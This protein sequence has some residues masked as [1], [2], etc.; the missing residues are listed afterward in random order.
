MKIKTSA[1]EVILYFRYNKREG[2]TNPDTRC[3][4]D[5]AVKA[6]VT[7]A[8]HFKDQFVRSVGRRISLTRALKASGASREIRA[9]IWNAYREATRK[10]P[11]T[12]AIT[13]DASK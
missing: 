13:I 3:V 2:I 9:E 12:I 10:Q 1:G 7:V 5:G 4:L 8:A 11:Q 6:D